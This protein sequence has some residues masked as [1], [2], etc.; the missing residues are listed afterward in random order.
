MGVLNIYMK[1]ITMNVEYKNDFIDSKE[2]IKSI[3]IIERYPNE[4]RYTLAILQDI[5][6]EFN[7]IPRYAMINISEYLELPL[8][9]IYSMANIL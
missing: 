6:K 9:D 4:K 3:E 7:Y 5:Q 1:V 8:S 2:S